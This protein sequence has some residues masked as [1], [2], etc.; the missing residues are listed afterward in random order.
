MKKYETKAPV[1]KIMKRDIKFRHFKV[2]TMVI[3]IIINRIAFKSDT[4]H[5]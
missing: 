5:K 1:N 3:E 4:Q 2:K